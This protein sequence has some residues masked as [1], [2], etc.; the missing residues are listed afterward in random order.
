MD[1]AHTPSDPDIRTRLRIASH[2]QITLHDGHSLTSLLDL[3]FTME[4]IHRFVVPRRTLARRIAKGE[5]LSIAENDSALRL[6]R[7]MALADRVFGN[8][9]KARRWLRKESRALDRIA[10]IDLLESEAG[11]RLVEEA[12]QQIDHGIAV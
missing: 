4:E 8:A 11:A 9:D 6:V 12:L 5:P 2:G 10:P 1:A 7:I 3:G